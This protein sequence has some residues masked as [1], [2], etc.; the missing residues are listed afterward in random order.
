MV[1]Y[2]NQHVL[3]KVECCIRELDSLPYI[4]SDQLNSSDNS[5]S[6]CTAFE[7]QKKEDE[8]YVTQ[9]WNTV[10]PILKQTRK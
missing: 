3:T 8:T 5:M 2:A 9:I 1:L 10:C 6:K 7:I 4:F